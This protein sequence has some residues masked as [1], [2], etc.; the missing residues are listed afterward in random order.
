MHPPERLNTP[1]AEIADTVVADNVA[2]EEVDEETDARSTNALTAKWTT[3]SP[4]HAEGENVLKTTQT[5]E[6]QTPPR[7]MNEYTTSAVPWDTSRPT[8]S[9]SNVPGINATQSIQVQH[10]RHLLKQEI[11]T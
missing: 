11:V 4:K 8:A 5:P 3:I 7:M 6:I 10:L 2:D 9:T 1:A